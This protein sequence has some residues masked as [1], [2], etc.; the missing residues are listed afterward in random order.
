MY[1][2]VYKYQGEVIVF[3]KGDEGKYR[4]L[5]EGSDFRKS[6]DIG[7]AQRSLKFWIVYLR[8]SADTL[9]NIHSDIYIYSRSSFNG[10]RRNTGC[11][12]ATET[13]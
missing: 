1:T 11:Y 4:A 7:L 8:F 10:K 12:C 5:L 3:E 2:I 6:I 13:F 9:T